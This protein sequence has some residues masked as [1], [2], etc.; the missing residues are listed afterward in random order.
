MPD[1]EAT[2]PFMG[3]HDVSFEQNVI[4]FI[5]LLGPLHELR[6]NGS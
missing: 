4:L 2:D 3:I 6:A 5:G 1:L